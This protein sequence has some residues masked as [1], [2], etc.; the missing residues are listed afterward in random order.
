MFLDK[1]VILLAKFILVF[2]LVLNNSACS[3]LDKKKNVV[4][5]K[6]LAADARI[7]LGLNYLQAKRTEQ[8]QRNLLLALEY[9]PDYERALSAMAYFYQFTHENNKAHTYYKKALKKTPSK[10]SLLNNYAVFLC[11]QNEFDLAIDYFEQAVKQEDYQ[12]RVM[13]LENAGIC[14]LKQGN[15][16]QAKAYF[17][18]VLSLDPDYH[19][20]DTQLAP[21]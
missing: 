13:S 12:S 4:F 15:K 11:R 17:K 8:A 2:F 21:D 16:I 14:R 19:F 20:A 7:D 9:A 6:K 18:R 5:D 1:V 3:S 10:G